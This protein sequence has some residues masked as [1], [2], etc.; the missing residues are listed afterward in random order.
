MIRSVGE[1]DDRGRSGCHIGMRW[2]NAPCTKEM[3]NA[4][5]AVGVEY[6]RLLVHYYSS[7]YP[8]TG[9]RGLFGTAFPCQC[10]MNGE[11]KDGGTYGDNW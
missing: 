10:R 2:C 5:I 1:G 6:G 9:T 3:V 7:S 4:S 8:W 11:G